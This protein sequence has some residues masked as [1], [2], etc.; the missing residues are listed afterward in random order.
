MKKLSILTSIILTSA[1]LGFS[2]QGNVAYAT[3]NSIGDTVFEDLNNNGV[4]DS[5]DQGI[6]GVTVNLLDESNNVIDATVTDGNGNYM[7]ENLFPGIFSVH[8]VEDTSPADLD[9]GMCPT[10]F[11]IELLAGESFLDADFCFKLLPAEIGDTVYQDS[12]NN[13]VQEASEPGIRRRNCKSN[14]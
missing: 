12:N 9:P 3:T 7:F 5:E 8:V 6:A 11:N 13:G 10:L 1:I 2:M 4:Q 14:L